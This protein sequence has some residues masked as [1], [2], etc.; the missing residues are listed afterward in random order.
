MS[1]YYY[2][3]LAQAAWH[4]VDTGLTDLPA[5]WGMISTGP[6]QIMGLT[7]RGHLQAGARA[8]VIAVNA[9]TRQVE[10]TVSAGRLAHLSGAMA[11][12]VWQKAI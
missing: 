5:A 8:D 6:A 10:L 11:A 9:E 7:D 2:P 1:D 12:R 3:A 4:L